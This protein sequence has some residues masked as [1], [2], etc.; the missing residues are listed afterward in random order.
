[1]RNGNIIDDDVEQ[2]NIKSKK[3]KINKKIKF[4][5]WLLILIFV[6]FQVF[7]MIMYTLGKKEKSSMWLYNSVNSIVGVIVPKAKDTIEENI[8]TIAALGDNYLSE[9]MNKYFNKNEMNDYSESKE[10]LSKYDFVISSLNTPIMDD[11]NSTK[12]I[13][14]SNDSILKVLKDIGVSVVATAGN[15]SMDKNEKGIISTINKIKEN[16]INQIG[17]NSSEDR[18]KP[19]IIDKNNIKVGVLSYTTSSNIKLAKGKEYL[20][21]LLTEE[22][23]KKD[24]EFCKSQNTDYIISYLNIPNEETTMVSSSQ[25]KSVEMLFSNGVNVVL[26]VGSKIVQS[27][28]EDLYDIDSKTK[29]HIY[30]IY[31]LGDFIGDMNTESKKTSVGADIK[32]TKNIKKNKKGEIINSETKML[33]GTPLFFYTSV[34][35]NK[36]ISYP[37]AASIEKYNNDKLQISE[38]DFK[39]IKNAEQSLKEILK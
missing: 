5:I 4:A 2:L 21:N 22:N 34:N 11:G 14:S 32:I 33:L 39:A 19:Y 18:N 15:H 16:D 3:K 20:I 1:M 10:L 12:K 29:S 38:K 31:S 24:I 28:S 37:I 7:E 23:V 25:T 17:L 35:N 36:I 27:S 30:T 8:L 13:Y 26:G 9:N 6:Y